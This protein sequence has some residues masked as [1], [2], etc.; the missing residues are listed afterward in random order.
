MP[1]GR[2]SFLRAYGAS[3]ASGTTHASAQTIPQT[4]GLKTELTRIGQA[5]QRKL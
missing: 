4:N 3:R 1:T 2:D 5:L